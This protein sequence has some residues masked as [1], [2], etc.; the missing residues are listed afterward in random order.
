MRVWRTDSDLAAFTFPL[1]ASSL[2][3]GMFC[4]R[5]HG[6]RGPD[7]VS[8]AFIVLRALHVVP[9]S[10]R[11]RSSS[12]LAFWNSNVNRASA[13]MLREIIF[14]L[15]DYTKPVNDSDIEY[16]LRTE[17]PLLTTGIH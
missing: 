10:R 11:L 4:Q 7:E 1:D 3:Q 8:S 15:Q 2:A 16:L 12:L 6:A 5:V 9:M 14:I 13:K 17:V